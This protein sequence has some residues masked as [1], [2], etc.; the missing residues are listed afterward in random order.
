MGNHAVDPALKQRC[1][2]VTRDDAILYIYCDLKNH[3]QYGK[4]YQYTIQPH[5]FIIPVNKTV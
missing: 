5:P 2:I 1:A 4:Q 3:V